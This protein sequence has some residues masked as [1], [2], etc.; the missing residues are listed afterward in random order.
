MPATCTLQMYRNMFSVFTYDSINWQRIC[1]LTVASLVYLKNKAGGFFAAQ[2]TRNTLWKWG[3]IWNISL[4]SLSLSISLAVLLRLILD[5]SV[6]SHHR[7]ISFAL[8][9]TTFCVHSLLC[10]PSNVSWVS[11]HLVCAALVSTTSCVWS[12]C[13]FFV[14]QC[15]LPTS[16]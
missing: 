13:Y 2:C 3:T 16:I 4:P 15:V 7:V 8:V 12:I 6:P 5:I 9:G 14:L 10:R 1:C 11:Q